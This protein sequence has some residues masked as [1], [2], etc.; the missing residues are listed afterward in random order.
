MTPTLT[1][2]A[3]EVRKSTRTFQKKPLT[4]ADLAK[5]SAYLNEPE[6]MIGPFGNQIEIELVLETEERKKDKIGTYGFIKNPQGYILG[7]S[8]V[9]TKSL[10]DY[11]FLDILQKK[12]D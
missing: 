2:N 11:A 4:P 8:I 5:V 6:N 3:I 9:E 1:L 10:F 12:V 7:S